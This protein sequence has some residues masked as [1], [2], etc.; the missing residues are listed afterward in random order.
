MT[1]TQGLFFIYGLPVI[2]RRTTMQ[3]K[4]ILFLILIFNFFCSYGQI[5]DKELYRKAFDEQYKMMKEEIPIDF[6]RAVFIT[7][8]AYYKGTLSYEIFKTEINQTG[9]KL[10][11]LIRQRGLTGY[12]T[13]GNWAV[14]TYMTDSISANKFTSY[15]YDFEDFSG[16]KDWT[17]MFTTKLMKTKSGNCHSLPYYYKILCEEIGASA[18][19]ALAP[20]HI[21]IKHVDENG[22]I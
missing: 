11:N 5:D 4:N 19:L 15:V 1:D 6:K 12:K 16:K 7:E 22:L 13:A 20:N 3:R 2:L 17:K 14:F 21:Y 18:H 9:N 10:K 8:N